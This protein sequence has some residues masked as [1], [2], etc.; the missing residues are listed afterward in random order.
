MNETTGWAAGGSYVGSTG[1]SSGRLFQTT[2]GGATWQR[3]S[4][5]SKGPLKSVCFLDDVHGWAVGDY[6]S[7]LHT[8]D[9][10]S[11]GQAE[12]TGAGV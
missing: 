7:A 9:G 1:S 3:R 4:L 6:G 10:G 5:G 11:T 8:S 2:D 12:E